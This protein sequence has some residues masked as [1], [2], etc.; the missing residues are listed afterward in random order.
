MCGEYR[1][2]ESHFVAIPQDAIDFGNRIV[3]RRVCAVLE[4]GFSTRLHCGYIALH[5]H[6]ARAREFLDGGTAR[7]VIKV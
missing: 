2:T 1:A 6:V 3:L 7:V 5:D 4:V